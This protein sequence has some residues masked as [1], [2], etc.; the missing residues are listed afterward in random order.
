MNNKFK[1]LA[2]KNMKKLV[3]LVSNFFLSFIIAFSWK[4]FY[5]IMAT[6][7]TFNSKIFL[8]I[9]GWLIKSKRENNNDIEIDYVLVC[10][11]WSIYKTSKIANFLTLFQC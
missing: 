9:L 11:N 10:D 8:H 5:R 4:K 6:D 1:G 7:K 3:V 2:F